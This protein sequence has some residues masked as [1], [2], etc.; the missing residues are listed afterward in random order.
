[1]L[2]K[3]RARI[4]Q[5]VGKFKRFKRIALRYEKTKRNFGSFL[6]GLS[7]VVSATSPNGFSLHE[8]FSVDGDKTHYSALLRFF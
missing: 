2:Y 3:G 1:M 8:L 5:A 7:Q 6:H 4:E